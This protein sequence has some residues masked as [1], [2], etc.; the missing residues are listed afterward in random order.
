MV[1]GVDEHLDHPSSNTL[2]CKLEFIFL[3][4]ND[5]CSSVQKKKTTYAVPPT[6]I[7]G[8]YFLE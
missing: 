3:L 1:E 4:S 8:I 6:C 7:I 5:I 2:Q